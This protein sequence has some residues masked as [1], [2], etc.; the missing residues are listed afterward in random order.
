MELKRL[1]K[2]TLLATGA[3]GLGA[4]SRV[5]TGH[6]PRLRHPCPGQPLH[7]ADRRRR[8]GC[9]QGPRRDARGG[10]AG[11]RR[12]RR[13]SSS[14]PR[15][16]P[17]PAPRASRRSVPGESM[18]KGL[19]ELIDSGVADRPVQPA[20]D[21]ASTRPMSARSRCESGRILGKM[22]VDKLGG[23]GAKGTVIIGICFPGVPGAREPRQG[24]AGI[25][26]RRR[27]AST[28]VGPFDVKVTEVENYNQ[29][30]AALR[31]QS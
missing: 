23:A 10:A 17:M 14:S 28:C 31:R 29:L 26:R 16:S 19:N 24:R 30:G 15:T 9:R 22:I 21:R 18:A 4:M 12:S 25:A 6:H 8:A 11:R 2:A 20:L 13:A 1:L 3:L 27:P 7:P 5:G